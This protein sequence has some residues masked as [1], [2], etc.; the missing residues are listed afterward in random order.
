M[1]NRFFSPNQQFFTNPVDGS[2]LA[3]GKLHFY[4]TSSS[5]PLDTYSEFTLN[6]LTANSN[7]VV[8]DSNGYAGTIFLGQAAYK[9]V[10][11]DENDVEIWTE[12]P[13]WASDYSTMAQVFPWAGDP[14][15]LVAGVAGIQGALPGSSMLWD[16]S[17]Q[18]L[19][20]CTT[21]GDAATAVWTAVN[22]GATTQNIPAP[23]GYLTPQGGGTPFTTGDVTSTS[24]FYTPYTG[25]VVPIY[26]GSGFA[27]QTFAEL[28]LDL[29]AA[30]AASTAYD[31]FVFNN[32]GV[33]TLVTGPAWTAST[34]GTSTRGAPSAI[35][36]LSG[37]WVNSTQI[38]ARNGA[39]TY[40]IA[41]NLATYLGSIIT[42]TVA[43]TVECDRSIGTNRRWG[44]WN[45]YNRCPILL[46]EADPIASWSYTTATFRVSR[47]S[48]ANRIFPFCGLPEEAI[49]CDFLQR[50]GTEA[51][52]NVRTASIGIGINSTTVTSGTRGIYTQGQTDSGVT[53]Q[54]DLKAA[55]IIDPA[56][57]LQNVNPLELG[58][59]NMSFWGNP[60]FVITARYR[61]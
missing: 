48:A 18:I 25:N 5:T 45:A 1:S 42:N 46:Q 7:P 28:T 53:M 41:A 9:V 38:T 21:T 58:D 29:N 24:I 6:P 34:A 10:L 22:E 19:Y 2:P 33:L 51:N 52:F 36:R 50:V 37:L 4:V 44:V 59:S 40:T 47:G 55:A 14:N 27:L 39:T 32:N 35:S 20:I 26:N 23:T 16:Y 12:D 61:G 49:Q 43:G 56:I 54:T 15:G 30:H 8:L 13:V 11:T 3:G 17:N 57:G 60:Y 31:V